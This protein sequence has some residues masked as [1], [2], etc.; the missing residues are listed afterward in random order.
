MIQDISYLQLAPKM[1]QQ[2]NLAITIQD[3]SC[4]HYCQSWVFVTFD[5]NGS[6]HDDHFDELTKVWRDASE[7]FEFM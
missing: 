6:R 7:D 2:Q 3:T 1:N 5:N 4:I